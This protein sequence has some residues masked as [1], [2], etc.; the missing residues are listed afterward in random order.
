MSG[1]Y[2]EADK[3]EPTIFD[4]WGDMWCKQRHPDDLIELAKGNL[5]GMFKGNPE[6]AAALPDCAQQELQRRG[7]DPEGS[8]PMYPDPDL[9]PARLIK[10]NS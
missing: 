5:H 10:D 4:V 8:I 7:I 1:A 6:Q 9:G 3:P 2:R